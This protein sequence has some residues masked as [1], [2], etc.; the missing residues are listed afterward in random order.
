MD[1]RPDC[2]RSIQPVRERG[3]VTVHGRAELFELSDPRRGEL[4]QA[5]LDHYLPLHGPSFAEWLDSAEAIGA[6]I[7]PERIFT[8]HLPG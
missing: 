6:R 2:V 1:P 7:H 4:R 5:M 3:T 8:F